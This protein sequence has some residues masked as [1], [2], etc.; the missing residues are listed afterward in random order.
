MSR[1][2][3]KKVESSPKKGLL[4]G[5]PW[6][7]PDKGILLEFEKCVVDRNS[8]IG[9]NISLVVMQYKVLLAVR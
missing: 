8:F 2:V 4:V 3:K 1:N 5:M 7:F 6:W 9:G